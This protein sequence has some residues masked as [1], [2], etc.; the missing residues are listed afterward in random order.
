MTMQTMTELKPKDPIDRWIM[1]VVPGRSFVDIGGIGGDSGNERVTFAAAAGA[2]K[3]VMA[4]IQP[5]EFWAWDIFR[6]KCAAKGLNG[7]IE[8]GGV[9]IR[10][11][12]TLA[13]VGSI[14]VVH[15]TGI[16]YHVQ[17]PAECLWNLRTIVGK[18]LIVNTV[19]FPKKVQNEE[20]TV[21]IPDC[22]ILFTAAL[23]S[24]DR[25]VV[26][27]YY[28][29]KFNWTMDQVAPTD[30]FAK[31]NPWIERGELTCWPYWYLYTDHAFR[32]L[33]NV[34]QLKVIEEWKWE[35]H[36][37]AALCEKIGT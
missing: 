31:C 19:T 20:G 28:K 24:R 34:C 13:Q 36:C 2:S 35:D 1:K 15:S 30:P 26:N 8:M 22:G 14:D 3:Y 32:A 37:L 27:A 9:D 33:L 21:E 10:K 11:R 23:T 7:A 18:Y 5:K 25:K 17:S 29:R 16:L 6:K 12:E 4:D